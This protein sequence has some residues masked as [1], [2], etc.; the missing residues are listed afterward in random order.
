MKIKHRG[1]RGVLLAAFALTL[2]GCERTLVYGE[3]SGFNLGIFVSPAESLPLE[4]NVGV[5]RRVV[6]IIPPA[7]EPDGSKVKG[8]AVNM[9]SRFDIHY[10][11]K[12]AS[13]FAGVHTVSAAFASGAA[14][15]AIA[16]GDNPAKVVNAIVQPEVIRLDNSPEAIKVRMALTDYINGNDD[17]VEEYLTLARE[18]GIVVDDE[19]LEE[20]APYA[21]L[22][23]IT[24]PENTRKNSQ[25]A[26]QLGLL[27]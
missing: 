17:R 27:K 13:P 19:L 18:R 8:E 1:T 15:T 22:V 14:A 4:V 5:K 24:R 10:Q 23:A 9:F 7:E 12:T 20:A 16:D 6:G 25:I 3:R 11:E 26:D 21:A 2:M